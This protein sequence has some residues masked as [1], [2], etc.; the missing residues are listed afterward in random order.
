M[1]LGAL[2]I[3]SRA[4]IT[5][6]ELDAAL[7]EAK[8]AIDGGYGAPD[9]CCLWMCEALVERAVMKGRP[10]ELLEQA[11]E[12]ARRGVALGDDRIARSRRGPGALVEGRGPDQPA[13]LL[14][15]A[16]AEPFVRLITRFQLV[17]VLVAASQL[18]EAERLADEIWAQSDPT[19][20]SY[21]HSRALVLF[22]RGRAEDA[23]GFVSRLMSAAIGDVRARRLVEIHVLSS[24]L[25][26]LGRADDAAW[27]DSV[28]KK[29][30][31]EPP[32]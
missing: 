8:R 9:E 2:V 13:L 30:L 6:G 17:F 7:D 11:V 3:S 24:Q 4:R 26:T 10:K 15:S 14:L 16:A 18:D 5:R 21:W 20:G 22:A 31:D 25:E 23:H 12:W 19:G 28:A 32:R 29:L 27:I 1:R